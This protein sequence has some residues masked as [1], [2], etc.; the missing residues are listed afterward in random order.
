MIN[1]KQL[2]E[3]VD[4]FFNEEDTSVGIYAIE[5][6][7]QE[8]VNEFVEAFEDIT[9]ISYDDNE[10]EFRIDGSTF[11]IAFSI[12]YERWVLYRVISI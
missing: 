1:E 9:V 3:D 7:T 11:K 10:L 6:V 12:S 5:K 2:V 4:D 8:V